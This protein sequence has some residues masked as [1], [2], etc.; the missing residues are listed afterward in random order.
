MPRTLSTLFSTR[1]ARLGAGTLLCLLAACGGG[2][3]SK[4]L[5]TTP[6]TPTAPTIPT[7]LV[8][9]VQF[10]PSVD[11]A[12]RGRVQAF[13]GVGDSISATGSGKLNTAGIALSPVVAL[14]AAGDALL[15]GVVAPNGTTAIDAVSTAQVIVRILLPIRVLESAPAAALNQYISTHADFAALSDSITTLARRGETFATSGPALALGARIATGAAL[16]FQPA[17]ARSSESGRATESADESV[18]AFARYKVVV[19]NG[20]GAAPPAVAGGTITF[21]NAS[22][23]PFSI[24]SSS[25]SRRVVVTGAGICALCWSV[26]YTPGDGTVRASADGPLTLTVRLDKE[27]VIGQLVIDFANSLMTIIGI[28]FPN[29]AKTITQIYANAN[30]TGVLTDLMAGKQPFPAVVSAAT[31]AAL[32]SAPDLFNLAL[33]KGLV[34]RNIF[35]GVT[36]MLLGVLS[37]VDQG[38]AVV[39]APITAAEAAAYWDAAPEVADA[40]FEKFKLYGGCSDSVTILTRGIEVGTIGGSANLLAN[41]FDDKRR[42]MVGRVPDWFSSSSAIA[43]IDA[44]GVLKSVDNGAVIATAKAGSKQDTSTVLSALTGSYVLTELNGILIPGETYRD[45]LYVITTSSGSLSLGSGGTFGYSVGAVGANVRNTLKFDEGSAGSG[46]Y[47][48]TGSSVRFVLVQKTGKI[49][50]LSVMSV[51]KNEMRGSAVSEDGS[52]GVKLKKQ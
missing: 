38:I 14:N 49:D 26:G 2:G 29:D 30:K 32:S 1:P 12:T 35:S 8:A 25:D 10:A 4:A 44:A 5:P 27:L 20:A 50:S 28:K 52:A 3:D 37:K 34:S 41:V 9:T 43:T 39:K 46:S 42:L 31:T 22:L 11:A 21:K 13:V 48:V 17:M 45:S 51:S 6:T 33:D 7:P 23:V 16:S 36:K 24:Q 47:K 18:A 40:C 19:I 15:A